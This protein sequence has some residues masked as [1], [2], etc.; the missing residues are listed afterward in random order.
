MIGTNKME[1]RTKSHGNIPR[2]EELVTEVTRRTQGLKGERQGGSR[3]SERKSLFGQR[4]VEAQD[5][6]KQ[7]NAQLVKE[8]DSIEAQIDD[9]NKRASRLSPQELSELSQL[10]NLLKILNQIM[11]TNITEFNKEMEQIKREEAAKQRVEAVRN[12]YERFTKWVSSAIEPLQKNA[13]RFNDWRKRG[14]DRVMAELRIKEE[15]VNE[16]LIDT[17]HIY[18]YQRTKAELE[19]QILASDE[20]QKNELERMHNNLLDRL[21]SEKSKLDGELTRTMGLIARKKLLLQN[22]NGEEKDKIRAE[23][24]T[25]AKEK[26]RIET[27]IKEIT[28]TI[29]EDTNL[30]INPDNKGAKLRE[31]LSEAEAMLGIYVAQRYERKQKIETLKNALTSG[32][33]TTEVGS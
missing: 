31:R 22:S 25:L 17:L 5:K 6:L 27:T 11:T 24:E 10:E 18:V 1:S 4:G 33:Q 26:T 19:K 23:L 15:Q 21:L 30:E 7:A 3:E 32:A 20:R 9:L 16:L 8:M 14:T 2:E 13:D 12:G 29:V 28:T